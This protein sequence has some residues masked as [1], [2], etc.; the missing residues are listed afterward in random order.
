MLRKTQVGIGG[1]IAG[2]DWSE[3]NYS[4]G[5]IAGNASRPASFSRKAL[6]NN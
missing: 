4:I 2:W 6:Q 5:K 1:R 3:R